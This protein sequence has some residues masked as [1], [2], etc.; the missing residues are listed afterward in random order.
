MSQACSKFCR[1]IEIEQ[2]N[3][4]MEPDVFIQVSV[5]RFT[6]NEKSQVED[7]QKIIARNI[8]ARLINES[9]KKTETNQ[10]TQERKIFISKEK[11]LENDGLV[12]VKNVEKKNM[13][14]RKGLE[15]RTEFYNCGNEEQGD[16]G[17]YFAERV[18][19]EALEYIPIDFDKNK[20]G[21][22]GIYCDKEGNL[23]VV[24]MKFTTDKNGKDSLAGILNNELK[25]RE[26]SKIWLK[27][28]LLKMMD[29]KDKGPDG[30]LY[31]EK[32]CEVAKEIKKA[33]EEKTL[34]RVLIHIHSQTLNVIVSECD[35]KENVIPFIGYEY[36]KK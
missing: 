34:R 14:K 18:A 19:V 29:K 16:L 7:I 12:G 8:K 23:I 1:P 30:E 21:I 17:E 5:G 4:T 15:K 13:D 22:D 32:N 2:M 3:A 20:H 26:L 25:P 10:F 31:S 6:F 27:N 33:M 11:Y 35:D 36:V 28:R 24:E 9:I